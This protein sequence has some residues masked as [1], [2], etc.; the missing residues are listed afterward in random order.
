VL[1]EIAQE[2]HEKIHES[3]IV[4]ADETLK[5]EEAQSA[6]AQAENDEN[7]AISVY[8]KIKQKYKVLNEYCAQLGRKSEIFTE[9]LTQLSMEQNHAERNRDKAQEVVLQRKR[10]LLDL[11]TPWQTLQEKH[12]KLENQLREICGHIQTIKDTPSIE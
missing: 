5:V 12:K 8:E 9:K 4:V 3:N 11:M 1:Q 10:V 7:N 2:L 6:C